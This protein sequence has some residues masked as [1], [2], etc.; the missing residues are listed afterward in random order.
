MADDCPTPNPSLEYQRVPQSSHHWLWRYRV[1]LLIAVVIAIVS[2]KSA[3]EL[4]WQLRVRYWERQCLAAPVAPG[5]TVFLAGT[6][7]TAVASPSV[8]ELFKMFGITY[9]GTPATVYSGQRQASNNLSRMIVIQAVMTW[10]PG[11]LADATFLVVMPPTGLDHRKYRWG[12]CIGGIQYSWGTKSPPQPEL[13]VQSAIEDSAD[14]SHFSFKYA[15]FSAN[16]NVEC[17]LQ[18]DGSLKWTETDQRGQVN[19]GSTNTP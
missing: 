9:A 14:A 11:K 8:T 16:Y 4:I 2:Y 17:W 19:T 6:P 1:R 7:L 18:S 12:D 13:K 5:T 15:V 10:Q 3:P